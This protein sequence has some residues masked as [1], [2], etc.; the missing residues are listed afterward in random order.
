ME[1]DGGPL[2]P[3][4]ARHPPL[5]APEPNRGDG[6]VGPAADLA[7]FGFSEEIPPPRG[8]GGAAAAPARPPGPRLPARR[9]W[10]GLRLGGGSGSGAGCRAL[11]GSH[12]PRL[13]TAPHP[14]SAL[15]RP[16]RATG[17]ERCHSAGPAPP[18]ARAP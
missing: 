17:G 8:P 3:R 12:L 6:E 18:P 1:A 16:G 5:P 14:A 13:L 11:L 4:A 15:T 9:P 10:R 7:R 2:A